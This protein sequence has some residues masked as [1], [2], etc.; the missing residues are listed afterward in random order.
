MCSQKLKGIGRMRQ[1]VEE[2][3][4]HRTP[5]KYDHHHNCLET[6]LC[7]LL[8]FSAKPPFVQRS[9][10]LPDMPDLKSFIRADD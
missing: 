4:E 5:Q 3:Q 6:V 1:A 2:P 8:L 9:S 10:Y 7:G